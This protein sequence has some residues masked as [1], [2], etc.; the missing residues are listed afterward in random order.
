[1]A[2]SV[3]G[4]TAFLKAV[5]HLRKFLAACQKS[6]Q[7]DCQCSSEGKEDGPSHA[8][9]TCN[10]RVWSLNMTI[11]A[12]LADGKAGEITTEFSVLL[13]ME[14]RKEKLFSRAG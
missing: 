10:G 11:Q 1:M 5:V 3:D 13:G 6:N 4:I 8:G 12:P 9:A 2:P 7:S 14:G